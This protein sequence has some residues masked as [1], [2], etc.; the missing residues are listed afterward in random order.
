MSRAAAGI[1]IGVRH[2]LGHHRHAH[3]C[4]RLQLPLRDWRACTQTSTVVL[5]GSSAGLTSVTLPGTPACRPGTEIVAASPDLQLRRFLLRDVGARDHLGQIHHR[6]NRR[7]A[8][9]RFARIDRPVG[10]H[11]V[12]RADDLGVA[13]LGLGARALALRGAQLRLRRPSGR[14]AFARVSY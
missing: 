10:D 13:Q 2:G 8:G 6:E 1:T 14:T 7:A 11:A 4:S 3:A 9:G 12:D 5:L